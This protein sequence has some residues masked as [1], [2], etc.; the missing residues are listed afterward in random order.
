MKMH[1]S[2]KSKLYA[3]SL[4]LVPPF[5]QMS[6]LFL[7]SSPSPPPTPSGPPSQIPS[8]PSPG[9]PSLGPLTPSASPP[10]PSR[11]PPPFSSPLSPV[12]D[13][14]TPVLSTLAPFVTSPTIEFI[15]K[16]PTFQGINGFSEIDLEETQIKR[17]NIPNP[18]TEIELPSPQNF[19][20]SIGTR[21]TPVSGFFSSPLSFFP[22]NPMT[23]LQYFS[24][25]MLRPSGVQ[26]G[27]QE[28]VAA[29]KQQ[30]VTT[31]QQAVLDDDDDDDDVKDDAKSDDVNDNAKFDDVN[32]DTHSD[33]V[34]D[35]TTADDTT[36]VDDDTKT[37]LENEQNGQADTN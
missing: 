30:V 35:D 31:S 13:V 18:A 1:V 25:T 37:E 19:T 32:A 16:P 21:T 28:E 9:P 2:I 36:V 6:L 34:K 15:P 5:L 23:P 11:T 17:Y 29:N 14:P 12:S 7:S 26:G 3:T 24:T 8:L 22:G 27:V 10:P 33:D 4:L 20:R